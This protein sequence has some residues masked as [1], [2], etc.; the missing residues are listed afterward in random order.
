MRGANSPLCGV[1][2]PS[3][4][5]LPAVSMP[6]LVTLAAVSSSFSNGWLVA[7]RY[8]QDVLT[9]PYDETPHAGRLPSA[10]PWGCAQMAGADERENALGTKLDT[11]LPFMVGAVS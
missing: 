6:L 9:N 7:L 10:P 1:V 4:T 11:L 5:P 8:C 2:K 3:G